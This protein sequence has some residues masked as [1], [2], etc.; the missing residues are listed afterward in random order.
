M[1]QRFLFRL[2]TYMTLAVVAI[3]G[4]ASAQTLLSQGKPAT[5]SSQEGN[6]VPASAFDGNGGTRW[7]SNYNDAEWIDVDLGSSVAINRVVLNWE[8]AFGKAYQIQISNDKTTWT[9]LQSVT[10][11][12]GGIDDLTVAGTGR[13]VRMNGVMRGTGYGYSLWEFQV[14]GGTP[15]ANN[16]ISTNKTVVASSQENGLNATNAVD[17]NATSRWGSNFSNAEWIYIDLGATYNVSR[18]ALSWEAAYGKGYQIQVS[19]NA[20]NWTTIYSTTT[21]DGSKDA[22]AASGTGRYVRLN[23]TERGTGYGYSLWEFEVYG[24]RSGGTISSSSAT[25]TSRSSSVTTTSKSSSVTTTSKSSSST[26]TPRHHQ[27]QPH[28]QVLQR[29]PLHLRHH[30]LFVK[31]YR[32]QNQLNYSLAV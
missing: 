8:T 20:T 10:A 11:G 22:F 6:L 26:T 2:L 3:P 31:K 1:L 16:L 9:T 27:L 23:G 24:S 25:T 7:A 12:D 21:G 29:R 17:G 28:R 4:L 14:Y 15:V 5:S 18:V 30:L 32:Q 19:D 13:Y